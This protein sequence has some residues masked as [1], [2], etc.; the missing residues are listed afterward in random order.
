MPIKTTNPNAQRQVVHSPLSY[1]V[2][3]GKYLAEGGKVVK[4]SG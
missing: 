2:I 3:C 1:L 4:I